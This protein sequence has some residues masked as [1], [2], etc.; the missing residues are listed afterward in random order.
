MPERAEWPLPRPVRDPS[1]LRGAEPEL[2]RVAV[3]AAVARPGLVSE[4]VAPQPPGETRFPAAMN[5]SRFGREEPGADV[6]PASVVSLS[7]CCLRWALFVHL[8]P[9]W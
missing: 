8:E 5:P 7:V 2:Q 4:L 6:L 3:E 1:A 9:E